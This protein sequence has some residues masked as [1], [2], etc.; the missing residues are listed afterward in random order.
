MERNFVYINEQ[1]NNVNFVY[2]NQNDSYNIEQ[3]VNLTRQLVNPNLVNLI[4]YYIEKRPELIKKYL[5][6]YIFFDVGKNK[7]ILISD[8]SLYP[9]NTSKNYY[10]CMIG[11][12]SQ[13]N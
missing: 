11:F 7:D 8:K 10:S 13:I 12:E 5:G 3:L 1:E 2:D 9:N 6:K 4:N